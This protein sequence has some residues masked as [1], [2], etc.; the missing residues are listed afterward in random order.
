MMGMQ[1][2]LNLNHLPLIQWQN[3][4]HWDQLMLPLYEA[5]KIRRQLHI[6]VLHLGEKDLSDLFG[7]TAPQQS[8][9]GQ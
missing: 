7:T 1:L 8:N 3:G 9:L 5:V 4:M 6:F 2:N